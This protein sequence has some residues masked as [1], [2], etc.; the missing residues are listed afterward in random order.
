MKVTEI[1]QLYEI[2]TG[3]KYYKP[4]P[5]RAKYIKWLEKKVLMLFEE[6]YKEYSE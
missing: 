3:E 2:E 4:S 1:R 6:V 5:E